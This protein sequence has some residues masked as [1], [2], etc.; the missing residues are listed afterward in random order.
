[1]GAAGVGDGWVAMVLAAGAG[2]G[3]VAGAIDV[4]SCP[5]LSRRRLFRASVL[6]NVV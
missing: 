2:A 5:Y 1:M 4:R 6:S 3:A